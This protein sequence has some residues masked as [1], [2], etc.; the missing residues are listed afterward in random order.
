MEPTEGAPKQIW[1]R[2]VQGRIVSSA[3]PWRSSGDGGGLRV[4]SQTKDA[5]GIAMNSI[6][7]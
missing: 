5:R 6:S 7:Y 1:T 3:G 4:T 2:L